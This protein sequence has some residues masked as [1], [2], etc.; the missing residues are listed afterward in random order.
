MKKRKGEKGKSGINVKMQNECEKKVEF[1]SRSV[2]N[3]CQN[4]PCRESL[5]QVALFQRVRL[6]RLRAILGQT[7]MMIVKY[8]GD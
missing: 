6:V 1:R 3:M 7:R 5:G 2:S 8:S 4:R